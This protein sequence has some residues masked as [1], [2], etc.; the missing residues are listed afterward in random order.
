MLKF[1]KKCWF[2]KE[3]FFS[4][5]NLLLT[6]GEDILL[7]CHFFLRDPGFIIAAQAVLKGRTREGQG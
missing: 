6:K 5:S 4:G 1:Q 3:A 2:C 7:D